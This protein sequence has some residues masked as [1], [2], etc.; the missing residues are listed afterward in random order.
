MP[1]YAVAL[2]SFL[3]GLVSLAYLQTL[4]DAGVIPQMWMPAVVKLTAPLSRSQHPQ[5]SKIMD[6]DYGLLRLFA[7]NERDWSVSTTPIPI[8]AHSPIL[9]HILANDR[10][11]TPPTLHHLLGKHTVHVSE[12]REYVNRA[13]FSRLLELCQGGNVIAPD[14]T[15]IAR[16][17]KLVNSV[18][19]DYGMTPLHYAYQQGDW[20][21]V[22]Y[23][24][25][26]GAD[27][28]KFDTAGR[29]P[30]NMSFANFVRNTRQWTAKRDQDAETKCE[31]PVVDAADPAQRSNIARLVSEGEPILI[32]NF[33]SVVK[34]T[35]LLNID[36][37]E[38]VEQN[39]DAMVKVGEVPYSDYFGLP[40]DKLRLKD[41]YTQH[42]L[43]KN[44]TAPLYIFQKNAAV[45]APYLPVLEALVQEHFGPSM[46]CPPSYAS[47]GQE[48]I[49][50]FLGTSNSGA[51]FHIHSDAI[52]L[53]VR[54]AKRWFILPPL[55]ALYSRKHIRRWVDEDLPLLEK[56]SASQPTV[57]Q[58][59]GPFSLD[60][61][62]APLQC[63]QLPG[64]IVYIPFD[65][66][67]AV[68]NDGLTLG[69]ALEVLNRRDT[70]V[71]LNGAT[72]QPMHHCRP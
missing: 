62:V 29:K 70:F 11:A 40:A 67:H 54:G 27:Q 36:L 20:D 71:S 37:D 57:Q 69:V 10:D 13:R 30:A 4:H 3:C 5:R 58:P 16:C 22:R 39:K 33:L 72:G 32:R 38:L 17:R 1:A 47:T 63:T 7:D 48:S 65:W 25:A 45:T 66:S 34:A 53:S 24:I 68:L 56:Q 35:H 64:D 44:A 6:D 12:V 49:H 14:A 26:L 31:L 28:D 60:Q 55:Q 51:P 2:V 19:P 8:S 15:R 23:L 50:Y 21:A 9:K 43:P 52:N 59:A 61:N 46:V 18:D 41:F 42:V